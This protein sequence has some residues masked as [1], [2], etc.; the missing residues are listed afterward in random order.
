MIFHLS[1]TPRAIRITFLGARRN[2]VSLGSV[3]DRILLPG[4]WIGNDL[5]EFLLCHFF[6]DVFCDALIAEFVGAPLLPGS[7]I[8][9]PEPASMRFRFI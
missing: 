7:R 2:G 4:I 3:A 6:L 8:R 1:G 9:S 5:L